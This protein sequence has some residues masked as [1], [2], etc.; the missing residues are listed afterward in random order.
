M[1]SLEMLGEL[2][3]VKKLRHEVL[4]PWVL[5]G[6]PFLLG[7]Q[8]RRSR[9]AD[10]VWRCVTVFGNELVY[11]VALPYLFW[12]VSVHLTFQLVM[13]W[14]V[15]FYAG[16]SLKNILRLP[17]PPSP[18]IDRMEKDYENEY[19][20]PSTHAMNALTLPITIVLS[21]YVDHPKCIQSFF[22]SFLL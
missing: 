15:G 13:L 1:L 16:N 17:R 5:S 11:L 20:L 14:S 12:N 10:V 7:L 22:H 19:G 21:L 9:V 4:L 2:R 8:G 3:A 18:P 6:T